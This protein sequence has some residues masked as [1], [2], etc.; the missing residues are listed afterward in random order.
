MIEYI[1]TSIDILVDLKVSEKAQELET[2]YYRNSPNNVN[3]HEYEKLLWK[4]ES[5]VRNFIK[6]IFY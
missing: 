6:V 3:N 2:E 4:L 1:K 5:D